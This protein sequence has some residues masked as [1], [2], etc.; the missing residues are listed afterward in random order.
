[1]PYCD[2][3]QCE[4]EAVIAVPVSE[5]DYGD[6]ARPFCRPCWDAYDI[7][8]QHGTFRAVFCLAEAVMGWG[9]QSVSP[10]HIFWVETQEVLDRAKLCWDLAKEEDNES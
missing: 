8:V 4:N 10:T 6:G 2:N 5:A 1:M 7:G 3:E 9:G